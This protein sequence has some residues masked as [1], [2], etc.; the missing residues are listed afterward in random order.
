MLFTTHKLD[1]LGLRTNDGSYCETWT[2]VGLSYD[3]MVDNLTSDLKLMGFPNLDYFR[4]S[5]KKVATRHRKKE[6]HNFIKIYLNFL[7]NFQVKTVCRGLM[8]TQQGS[9]RIRHIDYYRQSRLNQCVACS[10]WL[11]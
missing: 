2:Q 5:C 4:F 3:T 6:V 1:V 11:T 9:Y 8:Q 7:C 10:V